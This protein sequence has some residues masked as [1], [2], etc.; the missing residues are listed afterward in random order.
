MDKQNTEI[1]R[2]LGAALAVVRSVDEEGTPFVLVPNGYSIHDLE[3]TLATPTRKRGKVTM[4]DAA[5]FVDYF[6]LHDNESRIYGQVTPPKFV[7]VLNDNGAESI[8][9]WGDHRVIYDCP[10]SKE[11]QAWKTF[12]GLPRNQIEFSEFI[13]SNTLDIVSA[14]SD[15]PSGAEMLEVATNFKAQKTVN[16]ASG[17]RLDNGQV[18]FV[19]QEEIQGSAGAKGHIKVP[20]KFFIG[21]AVFEG[22]APYRIE[23]KLRY[24]LKEGKLSMWFDMVRDHKVLEAA[25]MDIWEEIAKGTDTKIWRGT[26]S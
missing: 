2:D 5:S 7:G 21:I 19:F 9:G 10:L 4:N 12:A 22:G 16:F 17:Q 15:E 8:T 11:W 18:D 20:E 24:R 1:V 23:C 25:F 26:P 3:K 14:S 13:E 6:N